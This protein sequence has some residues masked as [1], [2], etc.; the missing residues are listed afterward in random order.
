MSKRN[1]VHVATATLA[2]ELR[3]LLASKGIPEG[4]DIF[5]LAQALAFMVHG[6]QASLLFSALR[7]TKH[8]FAL[9]KLKS[10]ISLIETVSKV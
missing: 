5:Y 4:E 7:Q 8:R 3:S 6:T 10:V 9:R 2:R 1:D